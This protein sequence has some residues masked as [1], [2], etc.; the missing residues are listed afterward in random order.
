MNMPGFT[1]EATLYKTSGHYRTGRDIVNSFVQRVSPVRPAARE[2]EGEVIHVHSCPPGWT[3]YGGTCF[4]PPVTE[5]PVG[6]EGEDLPPGDRPDDGE[7]YGKGRGRRSKTFLERIK[8]AGGRY[9][10]LTDIPG[11]DPERLANAEIDCANKGTKSVDRQLA[12]FDNQDG[13]VSASCCHVYLKNITKGKADIDRVI[14]IHAEE[15]P[16]K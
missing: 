1:G 15:V 2:Q 10:R 12:C 8:P 11:T 4:P 14:C 16:P 7:P 13:T 5:P 6:G 3:D 9:C